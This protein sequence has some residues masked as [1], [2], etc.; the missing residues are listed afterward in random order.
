MILVYV[1]VFG[2]D[3][4]IPQYKEYLCRLN[5]AGKVTDDPQSYMDSPAKYTHV[6]VDYGGLNMPG[7]TGLFYA[8]CREL[9]RVV[10]ENPS[11]YFVIISALGKE[12]F[13]GDIEVINDPNVVFMDNFLDEEELLRILGP[14][15]KATQ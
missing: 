9:D 14:S 15:R 1:D 11:V 13:E 10:T 5:I 4:E 2:S 6:F 7:M 12:W 8:H 3:K